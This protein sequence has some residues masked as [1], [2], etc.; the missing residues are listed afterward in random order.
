MPDE[1][2]LLPTLEEHA[3]RIL[4][5]LDR[6][7]PDEL[8]ALTTLSLAE[9]TGVL[10]AL[11][12][13]GL[14]ATQ[15]GEDTVFR[16]LPPAV[17]LGNQLLRRH[18]A[19]ER[20]RQLVAELNDEYR[21]GVRRSEADHLVEV[22]IGGGALRDRL[23][24]LQDSAREEMLWFCRSNPVALPSGENTAE[25]DALR[26]GVR[27]QVIYDREFLGSPGV[28]DNALAGV[29]LGQQAR[30]LPSLPIRVAIADRTTAICPLVRETGGGETTAA[31]IGPSELLNA[32]TALFDAYWAMATP[33]HAPGEADTATADAPDDAELYVL[34][35]MIGGLPDKAIA[36]QLGVS[37]R[38]VQRRLDRLMALARVDTRPGLAYHAARHGWL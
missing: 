23:Q 22:I 28:L 8:A 1:L 17:A 35:L 21:A 25:L 31:V 27:Y 12:A 18:E 15:P 11:R 4:V 20:A 34:S 30:I 2:E 14:A 24:Q 36:S 7:R 5:K 38:T 3:Y 9:A 19:L 16:P 29:R 13:R 32:L 6:A 37:R 10:Y 26:R 33:V